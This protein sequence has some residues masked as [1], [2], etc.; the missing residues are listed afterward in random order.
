[1]K[2]PIPT[3]RT[4]GDNPFYGWWRPVALS[5]APWRSMAPGC[6]QWRPVVL[7]VLVPYLWKKKITIS[8]QK[9]NILPMIPNFY[10][11]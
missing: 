6:A 11:W 3:P 5:G 10:L 7:L 8:K 1:M 4:N 2:F 9:K